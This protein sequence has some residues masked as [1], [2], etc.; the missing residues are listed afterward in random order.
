MSLNSL[1]IAFLGGVI[2]FLSPCV[3]P[4][5]PGYL[6]F[7]TGLSLAELEEGPS[8]KKLLIPSLLFVGGFTLVFVSFGATASLLGGFL[9]NYKTVLQIASGVLVIAFGVLMMGFIKVPWLYGELRVDS[10]KAKT[11][12]RVSGFFMGMAFAAG[13]TPCIGP[14]LGSI[15]TMAGSTG[16]ASQGVVLLLAY[17]AGL[18]IPF[19]G[20]AFAFGKMRPFLSV[21]QRHSLTINRVGGFVLVLIG[22]LIVTGEFSRLA[23]L[24]A[25][26]L[27]AVKVSLPGLSK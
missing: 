23:L 10:S 11:F 17:S 8:L 18:G 15:L 3:I 16:T 5:I 25:G 7:L 2:S 22:V 21:M 6:S 13:W 9:R 20:V 27:P 26:Y 24:L 1:I 19:L 4:L 14:I 12:G